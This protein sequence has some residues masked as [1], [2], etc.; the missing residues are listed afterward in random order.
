MQPRVGK[1]RV[2]GRKCCKVVSGHG[3]TS[4]SALDA[5]GPGRRLAVSNGAPEDALL[6]QIG[7]GR[8]PGAC[9]MR[10]GQWRGTRARSAGRAGHQRTNWP[11]RDGRS[12]NDPRGLVA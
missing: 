9:C 12:A 2:S 10:A 8:P 7:C 1:G 5:L 3:L 4:D 6:T 11:M